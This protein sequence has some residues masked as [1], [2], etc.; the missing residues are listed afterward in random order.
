MGTPRLTV[1]LQKGLLGGCHS[2]IIPPPL[3]F[4]WGLLEEVARDGATGCGEDYIS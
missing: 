1:E 3:E 2:R 4:I